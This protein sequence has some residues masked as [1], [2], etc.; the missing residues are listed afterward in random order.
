MKTSAAILKAVEEIPVGEPFATAR[1]LTLGTRA[2]IDQTLSRAARAGTITRVARGVY[3]RQKENRFVGTIPPEPL[4]IAQTIAA[5]S[6]GA[7]QV[8]GAEAARRLG[9][10][11]QVP[12]QA[13]FMTTGPSRRLRAG[14]LRIELRHATP[15]KL[16]FPGS[17]IGLALAALWHLGRHGV[18]PEAISTI[19][20]RLSPS[21]FETLKS[22]AHVMPGWMSD[23]IRRHGKDRE[24]A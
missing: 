3:V 13:V 14:N 22:A 2:S 15:R 18:T 6:G 4:K 7:V 10:T 1:F 20:S 9:L 21:D 24:N 17:P 8:Q 11:T 5:A 23:A 12:T 19:R 16:S